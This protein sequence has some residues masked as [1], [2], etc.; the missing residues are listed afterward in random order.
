M[1]SAHHPH[2]PVQESAMDSVDTGNSG[3]GAD[4]ELEMISIPGSVPNRVLSKQGSSH[5]S[6]S[7]GS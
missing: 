2:Y 7:L 5:K 6:S 3:G 4:G 1:S